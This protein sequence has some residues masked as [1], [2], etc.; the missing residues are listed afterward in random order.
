MGK[1]MRDRTLILVT[2]HVGLCL[3]GAHKV[4]VMKDG[5]VVSQGT[6][7]EILSQGILEEITL[8]EKKQQKTSTKIVAEESSLKLN[9]MVG[10]G[11]GKLIAEEERAEG[12]VDWE[13]YKIYFIASG[14]FLFWAFLVFVFIISQT[15]QVGQGSCLLIYL[16]CF[17]FQKD[18]INF[19]L[20]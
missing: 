16:L 15:S 20:I 13:V 9:K 12:I 4:V 7:S 6:P 17:I 1:L 18:Y 2:H 5:H 19:I 10:K 14:G 11:D 8:E 3:H